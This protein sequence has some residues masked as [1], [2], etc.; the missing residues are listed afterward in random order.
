MEVYKGH[1]IAYSLGNFCTPAGFSVTGISGYAP[2]LVARIDNR[3]GHLVD[4]Q[5]HS[6]LQPV[7]TGP[8]RDPLNK[9]AI[10]IRALTRQDFTD[11][12]LLINDDGSFRPV[13]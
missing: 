13:K 11:A 2:L 1:L 10:L 7:R 9:V 5:I 4:G 12:H 8:R 3:D 6:F